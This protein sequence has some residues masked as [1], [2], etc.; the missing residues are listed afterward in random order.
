MP[1]FS[2]WIQ[3]GDLDTAAPSA[4]LAGLLDE[5]SGPCRRCASLDDDQIT[6]VLGRWKAME[7]WVLAGQLAVITEL[8]RRRGLPGTASHFGVPSAWDDTLTEEIAHA[9]G[10]S[11]P[12]AM[13]LIDMAVA[14]FTRLDATAAALEAGDLD[15]TKVKII[16]E[17]TA[18][19]DDAAASNAEK[20]ALT[21]AG[22]SFAGKTPGEL[23]KLIERAAIAADPQ[24]AEKR[25]KG[26][27]RSA[28]VETWRESSG[29]MAIQASGLNPQAA[30]DAGQGLEARTKAYKRAGLDGSMDQLRARALT[31]ALAGKNPLKDSDTG[32]AAEVNLTLPVLQLPLLSVLGIADIAGEADGW[33]AIDPALVRDLAQAAAAAGTDSTWHLTLTD[34]NGYAIGHGCSARIRDAKSGKTAG[35]V[36]VRL[37]GEAM[38]FAIHPIPVTGDCDH[39][40]ECAGHDPSPLL[41]HLVAVRDGGCV[42]PG[43]RKPA[44]NCDFEHS[45]SFE[46]A[47][48]TCF[49]NGSPKC[50]RGHHIKQHPHWAVTQIEPG[51]QLWEVPS[52]RVYLRGP[53]Q[54]P[55]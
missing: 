21:R 24:W 52:G 25:R 46:K 33:G 34:E 42:Q 39:R 19:L 15:Y 1:D 28:R 13:K 23:G 31:D 7:G 43:C 54:Y 3:N 17:A 35:T 27:E 41:R 36:T 47:G 22:G 9:L 29:T 14:L 51:F 44:Q 50:R 45:I 18:P 2:G 55:A 53:R 11:R 38:R 20:L 32:L 40:L 16:Y 4:G 10:M 12:A 5:V 30:L 6:G 49:C 26:A 37:P 48:L 8:V